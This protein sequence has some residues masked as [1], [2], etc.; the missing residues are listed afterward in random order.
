MTVMQR[1]MV[2]IFIGFAHDRSRL[3]H[4]LAFF[5]LLITKLTITFVPGA[6]SEEDW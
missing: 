6:A 5:S 1:W 4:Q 3:R 2:Y